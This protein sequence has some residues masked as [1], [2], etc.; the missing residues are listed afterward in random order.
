MTTGGGK[1]IKIKVTFQGLKWGCCITSKLSIFKHVQSISFPKIMHYNLLLI[2][3]FKF[4]YSLNAWTMLLRIFSIQK[5]ETQF[6]L[7]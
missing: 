4:S 6:K 5:T 7:A 2:I 3:L 1:K